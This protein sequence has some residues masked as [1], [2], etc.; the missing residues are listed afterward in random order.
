MF[1]TLVHVLTRAHFPVDDVVLAEIH[2]P[3]ARFRSGLPES[4]FELSE[5]IMLTVVAW[6]VF[7]CVYLQEYIFLLTKSCVS[8]T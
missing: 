3:G 8:D 7:Q 5:H 2:E 1:S 4:I 6:S